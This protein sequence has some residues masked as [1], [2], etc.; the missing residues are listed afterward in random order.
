M[1]TEPD[2]LADRDRIERD[3]T[4]LYRAAIAAA[5]P[6]YLVTAALE[7][8]TPATRD[9]P[10][11]IARASRVFL[12]AVGKASLAMARSIESHLG[13]RLADTL[14]VV[15]PGTTA[16]PSERLTV[17]T[18]AHPLPDESSERAARRAL[19][20]LHRATPSDLVI[21]ALSG[22]ASAMFTLPA[23]G[24]SLADKIAINAALLRAGALIRE[25]NTVRKH[26]SA[27][28]GGRL[29]RETGGAAVLTLVLSD[30]PGNDL[31]TVGSGLT[32]PDPTTFADAVGVLKRRSLW[33]RAPESVRD[34]LERGVA[35][36]IAETLKQGAPELARVTNFIIGDNSTALDGLERAARGLGYSVDRWRELYGEADD[37]GR[38][39]AAH[40]AS[41][42]TERTCVIAGGEPVAAVRGSGKGGRAQQCALATAIEL[43]RIAPRRRIAALFAGT[44]GIDGPT[45]A[46][47]AFAF[48]HSVARA[49]AAGVSASDSLAR[50]DAY[51][52]FRSIDDLLVTGP[53]GTNVAD[54]FV[55]LI[56]W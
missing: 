32:A 31:A 26:L 46:A 35:G 40:L 9:V 51:T 18:S 7:G 42:Q 19:E 33:G 24:V 5:D 21:V 23:E 34:Y 22:G 52:F 29:L 4:H 50:H 37:L 20:M 56:N 13:P 10:Q 11:L 16:E 3:L 39:L 54:I 8:R 12:L 30:V 15:P 17:C 38:A 47:G 53:T 48:P 25:F 44:D 28:K 14:V 49:A 6:Q 45:D 27:V 36:E 2:S 1:P 41:I 43:A 55:G